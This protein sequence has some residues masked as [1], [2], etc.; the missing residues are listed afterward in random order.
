[1]SELSEKTIDKLNEKVNFSNASAT[2]DSLYAARSC[3]NDEVVD[4]LVRLLKKTRRNNRR[5][6]GRRWR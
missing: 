1:M 5:A 6:C 2:I 4:D 3:L